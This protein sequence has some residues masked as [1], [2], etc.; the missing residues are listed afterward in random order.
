MFILFVLTFIICDKQLFDILDKEAKDKYGNIEDQSNKKGIF[1]SIDFLQKYE[2]IQ[3]L[4]EEQNKN[5]NL[6]ESVQ[7]INGKKDYKDLHISE[8]ESKVQLLIKKNNKLLHQS[9]NPSN[10]INKVISKED[11]IKTFNEIIY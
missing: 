8:L 1:D 4:S 9:D 10:N 5:L 2:V 3:D 7:I 11:E 6:G